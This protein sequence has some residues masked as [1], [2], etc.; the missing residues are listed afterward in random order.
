MYQIFENKNLRK[1][2]N[3][4]ENKFIAEIFFIEIYEIMKI[5]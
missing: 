5:G 4:N 2:N 1:F 3:F